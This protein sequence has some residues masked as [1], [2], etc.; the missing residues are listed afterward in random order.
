MQDS[1]EIKLYKYQ[2]FYKFR[3]F[4]PQSYLLDKDFFADWKELNDP[5]EGFFITIASK[6]YFSFSYQTS[7]NEPSL[8]NELIEVL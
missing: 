4:Y 6:H 8:K 7:T 2:S 5:L 1:N 3:K